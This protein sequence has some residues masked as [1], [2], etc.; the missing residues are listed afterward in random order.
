MR[1]YG[2]LAALL[3]MTF[4]VSGC[5]SDG[6]NEAKSI[7]NNQAKVTEDY[8]NGLTSAKNADDVIDTIENYTKGMKK[9]I[10]EL[11]EFQKNYPEYMQGKMPEEMK[12]DI[13]RIEAASA[14]IPEAMMKMTQYM[15][16]SRVQT[17]MAQM[18]EEMN[19][20]Q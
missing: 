14:K 16:D 19:K 20:L 11:Q 8:V 6:G 1:I 10:P 3:F 7:M 12:A 18:G 17:A 5:G 15:M 13:K 2:I 4:L 9:L